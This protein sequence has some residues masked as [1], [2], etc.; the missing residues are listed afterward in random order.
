MLRHLRDTF[1]FPSVPN[2]MVM[3]MREHLSAAAGAC[4]VHDMY[5]GRMQP[6]IYQL[7]SELLSCDTV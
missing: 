6:D 5:V 4:V 3:V 7:H 1:C 2:G